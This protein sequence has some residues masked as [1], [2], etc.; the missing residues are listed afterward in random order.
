MEKVLVTGGT[1]FIGC[2]IAKYL[3]EKGYDVCATYHSTVPRYVISGVEYRKVDLLKCSECLE[4]MKDIDIVIMCAAYSA[5]IDEIR[6]TPLVLLNECTIININTLEAAYK[7]HVKKIIFISSGAVY[8]VLDHSAKEEEGFD[9]DPIDKYFTLGW[10]KRYGEILCKS[11]AE[12]VDNKINATVLR[13]DNVYGPYDNFEGNKAHVIPS[14]IRKVVKEEKPFVVWGD[15]T[16]Q[17]DF[18]YVE[19]LAKTV[20][21]CLENAYGFQ[22]YN[23]VYGCNYSLNDA[24]KIIIEEAGF[25]YEKV[26]I[27][28]DLTKPNSISNRNL[29][30]DK[31]EKQLGIQP[32]TNFREGIRKTIIWYKGEKNGNNKNTF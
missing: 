24:L 17:K 11:Y 26:P 8:P 27:E 9:K 7:T 28:Y 29:S 22:V 6:K 12:K 15:G 25:D 2:N 13:I 21:L 32:K 10:S 20:L 14:L 18:L 23:E 16:E 5:G 30:N 3:S 31:I 1:G 4:A 19:D